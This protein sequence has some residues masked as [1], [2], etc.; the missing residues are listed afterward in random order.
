MKHYYPLLIVA[1]LLAS[2]CGDEG[3][4][5][6]YDTVVVSIHGRVTHE[7][8]PVDARVILREEYCRTWD[9]W[10]CTDYVSQR[11]TSTRCADGY[12]EITDAVL[13]RPSSLRLVLEVN[14]PDLCPGPGYARWVTCTTEPQVVNWDR[15]APRNYCP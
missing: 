3:P 6:A 2:S 8:Q 14:D 13:C 11:L 12:Y 4:T 1:A 5:E 7:G 9:G 10:A 15:L